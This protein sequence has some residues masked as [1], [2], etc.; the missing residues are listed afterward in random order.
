MDPK[1]ALAVLTVG[2]LFASPM[3]AL[4]Q[5]QSE[6][7]P[8]ITAMKGFQQ[9]NAAD[10]AVV[11]PMAVYRSALTGVRSLVSPDV[12]DWR[13]SNAIVTKHLDKGASERGEVNQPGTG[14]AT[15]A[16]PPKAAHQGH[17]G[18]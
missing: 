1:W 11:V 17:Q 14:V 6:V 3:A 7:L 2:V 15:G 9:A 4:A 18:K 10:A 13:Q 8:D 5:T 12:K 16:L